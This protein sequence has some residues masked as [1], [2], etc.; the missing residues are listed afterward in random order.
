MQPQKYERITDFTEREGDD[1]DHSALNDEFDAAA[2]TTDQIR[3]NLALIQ[4]D[5]GALKNGIVTADALDDSA[6]DAVQ[7]SV[8]AATVA[9]QTA[10]DSANNAAFSAN[11]ARDTAV[12]AKV[13]AE[14]ARDAAQLNSAS[15]A[16][17]AV[18][19]GNSKDAAAASE[20]ASLSNKNSS[21]S[22]AAAAANS[23]TAAAASATLAGQKAD[24][25][26]TNGAA[27]VNL[28]TAQANISITKAGEAATSQAA[29]AA[30]AITAST[31]AGEAAISEANSLSNKNATDTNA[32][33]ALASKNAAAT[34]ETNSNASKVAAQAA[35][36]AA[37]AA[38]IAA[39]VAE[40][41]SELSATNSAASATL[42][43]D[44]AIKIGSPV[45]GSD[46]SSKKYS[47]DSANSATSSAASAADSLT[48]AN[49]AALSK[50]A[51]ETAR[52]ATL[53]ALDSF[54][55][56]YLGQK[57]SD[58]TVD[59]DGNAL[60][61]GALY[62]NTTAPGVMKVYD[63][64]QWLAA[65]A[66][67]SGALIANNNLSD[68]NNVVSARA[69][70]GLG[71]FAT[72][73]SALSTDITD[74]GTAA[75]AAAPVQS[76]A[77]KSGVVTIGATDLTATGTPTSSKYLRGDNSWQEIIIP[78]AFPSGT[79]M[80]FQQTAA[81]TGWTKQTTHDNKA[82]RVVSGT[83]GSGGTTNFT[84]VFTNQTV[85]TSIS[86]SGTTGATTLSTAQMPSHT[87]SYTGYTGTQDGRAYD[88]GAPNFGALNTGSTGGNGSHT[89]SFSGSGSGTSSAV[90]LNVAYVDLIIA[91]KD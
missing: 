28:A 31:K 32:A 60:V 76:V 63:G 90:T 4:R 91:S 8:N 39:Q 62:F 55:D 82:L 35:Q 88:A 78:I 86:V 38:K 16:N 53:A 85:S 83:A 46:Y 64:T 14:T 19:A 80:L 33:S 84:S 30:S 21:T 37:E 57:S 54:D 34:S 22:S 5:D 41:A 77:G 49:S 61:V 1:T 74:F 27:Q 44:W 26:T 25:A 67:L 75:S 2:L 71:S 9:A 58:P 23:A 12:A 18:S 72:K 81:P 40:A 79:L 15:S 73:S 89:H 66:S 29:A 47:I 87:H 65:Y 6:F 20:A 52:D 11:T 13:S 59:N 42:A 45:S 56:R 48:S 10:A 50:T 17:S 7:A 43:S 3:A 24:L 36:S 70:L 51:A 68:L 69:N